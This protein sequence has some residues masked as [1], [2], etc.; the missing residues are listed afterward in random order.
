MKVIYNGGPD[1]KT[2]KDSFAAMIPEM[3]EKD[4]DLIYLD[5]DLMSCLGTAK[6]GKAHPDRAINVGIAESNMIGIAA[7]LYAAGFKPICHTFGPFASRRCYDQLFMSAAY[8]KND[9]TVIGTDPG[10]CAA[11]NG[12]THMPFE[13]VALYSAIPGA[14]IIDVTDTAML[15][16]IFPK[17]V[18]RKGVK[19]IRANRKANDLVYEAGSEFEIG[20]GV[21]LREGKDVTI[22]AAGYMV[23]AAL[24]AAEILAEKGI[25]AS[26]IDMFTIKPLDDALVTEYAKKTGAVVTAENHNRFGGLFSAVAATLAKNAPVPADCVAV[27]DEFGEVGPV[28]YLAKRFGLTAEHIVDVVEKTVARK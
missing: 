1:V 19:Y 14:T 3:L 28:D 6:Y 13:D 18:E 5:A 11:M 27:E 15:E 21:V 26:V 7:G 17:L 23:G 8:A 9:I 10:V 12:G 4:Q 22:I 16:N 20:K 24:K 25:E 2:F